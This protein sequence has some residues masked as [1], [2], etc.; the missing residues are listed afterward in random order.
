MPAK[1]YNTILEQ[2]DEKD[3]IMGLVLTKPGGIY[4]DRHDLTRRLQISAEKYPTI[5]KLFREMQGV[6]IRYDISLDTSLLGGAVVK[7]T[8]TNGVFFMTGFGRKY[9]E[10]DLRISY[11]SESLQR[12]E[13]FSD[14]FWKN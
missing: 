5:Q 3:I 6:G 4:I 14:E 2:F 8:S 7:Q 1:D 9:I 11:P 10:V 12:L 13:E